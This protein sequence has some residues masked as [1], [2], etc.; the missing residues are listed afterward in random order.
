MANEILM[1]N[2]FMCWEIRKYVELLS[3]VILSLETEKLWQVSY[4]S[5]KNKCEL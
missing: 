5:I 4:K 2:E 1:W 3:F